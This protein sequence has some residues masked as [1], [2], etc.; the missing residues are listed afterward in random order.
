MDPV[1]EDV[2]GQRAGFMEMTS[3]VL[4]VLNLRC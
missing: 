1:K 2:I 4:V 3:S